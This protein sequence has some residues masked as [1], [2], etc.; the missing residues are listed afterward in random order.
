MALPVAGGMFMT[1]SLQ[2]YT[3]RTSADTTS[4]P[5]L[6]A[7]PFSDLLWFYLVR[8]GPMDDPWNSPP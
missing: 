7:D 5:V 6:P 8:L 3:T 1:F 4:V 2:S